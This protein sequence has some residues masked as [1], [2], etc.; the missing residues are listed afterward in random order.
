VSDLLTNHSK[1]S[2][3]KRFMER[4]PEGAEHL[5]LASQ[6][7]QPMVLLS[8]TTEQVRTTGPSGIWAELAEQMADHAAVTSQSTFLLVWVDANSNVLGTKQLIQEAPAAAPGGVSELAMRMDGSLQ[9]QLASYQKLTYDMTK[10]CM[11]TQTAQMA[12]AITLLDKYSERLLATV[13][14]EGELSAENA[15][16]RAQVAE[17]EAKLDNLPDNDDEP[18][19]P[20]AA[21]AIVK[22]LEPYIPVMM[23]KLAAGAPANTPP[24]QL[25]KGAA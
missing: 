7:A 13:T 22:A 18:S 16:L 14:R 24:Q 12:Q 8:F 21:N 23:A 17:L 20:S 3:V 15:E 2:A 25:D 6:A 9:S 4:V 19:E 11:Q 5:R 10:L 1:I